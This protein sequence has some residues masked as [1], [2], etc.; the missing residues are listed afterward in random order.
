MSF[1]PPPNVGRSAA[2]S[3]ERSRGRI[4]PSGVVVVYFSKLGGRL[5][6]PGMR[7]REFINPQGGW[8]RW[9]FVY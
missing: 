5:R 1:V 8:Q 6:E 7:R 4:V 2:P 3:Q 9:R